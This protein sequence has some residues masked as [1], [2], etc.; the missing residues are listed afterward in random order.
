METKIVITLD[1]KLSIVTQEG[2]FAEGQQ[3]IKELLVAL[4]AQ[5]L[6]V[7]LVGAIEQHRHD[8]P[9]HVHTHNHNHVH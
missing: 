8:D 6:D 9:G 4:Q 7:D 1:G 5:G 3:K 2:N